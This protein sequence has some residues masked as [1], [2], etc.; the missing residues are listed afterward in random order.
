MNTTPTLLLEPLV[1]FLHCDASIL[2]AHVSCH[3]YARVLD[4]LAYVVWGWSDK[5]K[6]MLLMLMNH[7]LRPKRTRSVMQYLIQTIYDACAGLQ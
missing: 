7:A 6:E 2:E 3:S 5:C 4:S 1:P